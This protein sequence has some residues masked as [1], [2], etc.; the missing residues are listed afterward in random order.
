MAR[1]PMIFVATVGQ[2][3]HTTHVARAIVAGGAS[4]PEFQS[5]T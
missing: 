4:F 2:L 5:E 1:K 3:L